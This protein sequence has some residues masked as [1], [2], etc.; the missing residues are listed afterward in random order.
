ME[1]RK[2]QG[3]N[4]NES[5]T[6]TLIATLSTEMEKIASHVELIDPNTKSELKINIVD[7]EKKNVVNTATDE[8]SLMIRLASLTRSKK[9]H[10]GI[11]RC[12]LYVKEKQII[13]TGASNNNIRVWNSVDFSLIANLT[14]HTHYVKGFIQLS[15]QRIA[16]FSIDASIK[17]WNLQSMQEEQTLKI[18]RNIYGIITFI[19]LSNGNLLCAYDNACMREWKF[20]VLLKRYEDYYKAVPF[21]RKKI[22]CLLE[23]SA[24]TIIAGSGDNMNV[25]KV[26]ST[27]TN[28]QLQ[29][30]F[31][32]VGHTG[33]V[34]NCQFIGQEKQYLLSSSMDCCIKLWSLQH[35]RCLKTITWPNPQLFFLITPSIFVSASDEI[36]V[37]GLFNG[38]SWTIKYENG[39]TNVYNI[40]NTE[41]KMLVVSYN[42]LEVWKY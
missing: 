7:Q 16:S 8:K 9:H 4:L 21:N 36:T 37:C 12:A 3:T 27:P 19:L 6:D 38:K 25:Y 39:T 10:E 17:I 15:E 5:D 26:V 20:N 22:N 42:G 24:Q 23:I 29:Y 41:D 11:A 33:L 2:G 32:F 14:G 34:E 30:E 1:V 13:F 35:H 18:E 31:S 28:F 40:F